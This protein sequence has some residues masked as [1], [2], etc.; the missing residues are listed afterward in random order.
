MVPTNCHC[1][2][3]VL[4]ERKTLPHH[5]PSWVP[6]HSRYF[7]TINCRHR[8]IDVLGRDKRA[9]KLLESIRVYEDQNKWRVFVMIVMPDHIHMIAS[10]NHTMG[11]QSIIRSW[12][13]YHARVLGIEWQRDYFEHRIRNQAEYTKLFHYVLM[14]PVRKGLVTDWKEWQHKHVCG[15]W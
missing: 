12:K 1:I 10:F 15:V 13:R 3:N 2:M 4:P 6:E 5:I 14:N 11:I 9:S 8:G 7:I